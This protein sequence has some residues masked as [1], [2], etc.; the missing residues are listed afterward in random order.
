MREPTMMVIGR[1]VLAVVVAGIAAT[2]AVPVQ[3]ATP[4]GRGC[5]GVLERRDT[6]CQR[7]H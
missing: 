3:A 2:T 7:R 5:G 6:G 1:A 4:P